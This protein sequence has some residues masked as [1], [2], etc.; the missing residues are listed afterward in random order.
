MTNQR[1]FVIEM[2]L[3]IIRD[4]FNFIF[5]STVIIEVNLVACDKKKKKIGVMWLLCFTT[6]VKEY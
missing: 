2:G 4:D 3:R 5:T 6:Y 1:D